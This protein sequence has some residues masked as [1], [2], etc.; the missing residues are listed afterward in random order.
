MDFLIGRLTLEDKPKSDS[1]S[2]IPKQVFFTS[3]GRIG[4]VSETLD[5]SLSVRLTNLLRNLAYIVKGPG[6]ISYEE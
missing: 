3:S 5:D 1:N 6:G 4:I 2:L